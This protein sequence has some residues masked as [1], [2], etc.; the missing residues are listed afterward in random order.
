MNTGDKDITD[1]THNAR[2]AFWYNQQDNNFHILRAHV[3]NRYPQW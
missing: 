1:E 3:G 2:L